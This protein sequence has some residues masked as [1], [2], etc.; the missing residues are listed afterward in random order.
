MFLKF[1]NSN[2]IGVLVIIILLPLFYWLPDIWTGE[3]PH[4]S[5]YTGTLPGV[6]FQN[7]NQDHS[8]LSRIAALVVILVNAY[9]LVLLNRIHIFIPVRTQLPALYYILLTACFNPIHQLTAAL[10]SS[11]LIILV[12]YRVIATYKAEGIAYNFLDAGFLVALASLLYFPA[13]LFFLFLL[14]GLVLLRPF[15][16]REWA[17]AFLGLG[18]PYLFLF[19]GYY[20]TDMKIADYFPDFARIL[21]GNH[22]PFT[23]IQL[24]SW[25]FIAGMLIYGSYFMITTIDIMKIQSRKIFLFFLWLFMISLVT[26]VTVPG[27][28]MEILYFGAIPLSFLFSHFFN[29]CERNWINEILFSMFLWLIILL[30]IF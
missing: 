24:T 4:G 18:L 3:P 10:L 25:A 8:V 5:I 15:M 2:R 17:Y 9:L 21:S 30:R 19:S 6:F 13:I 26:Y 27:T 7:L 12:M 16:W 22:Q 20:L 29:K 14:A 28:G 1:F 11:F 23:V